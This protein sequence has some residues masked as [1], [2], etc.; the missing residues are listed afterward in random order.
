MAKGRV[1]CHEYKLYFRSMLLFT[2]AWT[3]NES[4]I[5]ETFVRYHA[6]IADKMLIVLIRGSDNSEEILEQLRTEG[7]PIEI[8]RTEAPFFDA[9]E[10]QKLLTAAIRTHQ[11]A[12]VI[13]LDTDEFLTASKP[14][15]N[16][17]DVFA[18]LPGDVPVS[19]SWVSHV[20][21]ESDVQD[22]NVLRRIR[23]HLETERSKTVK[24]ALPLSIT[25]GS[26]W[27][28]GPGSHRILGSSIPETVHLDSLTLRH[29]PIRSS[30]QV[31]VKS[32]G[33]LWVLASTRLNAAV[34][35]RQW[36]KLFDRCGDDRPLEVPELRALA[37]RYT[38]LHTDDVSPVKLVDNP[39][40]C[41]FD[42]QYPRKT[43]TRTQAS[44]AVAERLAVML[45]D[46]R[47]RIPG[48]APSMMRRLWNRML[49][50]AGR[51]GLI[52]TS[53]NLE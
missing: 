8:H 23:H 34:H 11:P 44:V 24:T 4:D 35:A 2:I 18:S 28:F 32:L 47:V 13:P 22:A 38:V 50:M 36:K 7:L 48:A 16:V 31:R 30:E 52:V 15:A 53:K 25:K 1:M 51:P 42:L 37:D 21:T 12:W 43:A 14:Q 17:R 27:R 9:V 41:T 40:P 33:W 3:H 49:I 26:E 20:P 5:L 10:H 19:F 45:H 29:F 46:A 39:V 6:S